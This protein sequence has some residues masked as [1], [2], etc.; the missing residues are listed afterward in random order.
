VV[1]F[2]TLA[3]ALANFGGLGLMIAYLVWRES[4]AEK[5]AEKQAEATK[6]LAVSLALLEA[7]I[8]GGH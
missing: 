7:T 6:A 5:L 2:S 1:D 4:R 3:G 8:R